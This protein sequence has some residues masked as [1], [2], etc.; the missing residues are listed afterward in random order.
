MNP[1]TMSMIMSSIAA[2]TVL[3]MSANHWLIAWVGLEIN[4]LAILPII[5]TEHHPRAMEATTKY[6]LIQA[7]AS[8]TIMFSSTINALETGQWDITQLTYPPATALLTIAL[9]MKLGLAPM[10]H[11][12]PEVMQGTKLKTALIIATWQKLAPMSL[13]YMTFNNLSTQILLPLALTSTLLAGWSALNQT[14]LRKIM[15]FS[16]IAHIGWMISILP[17]APT[18]SLIALAVY[19]IMTTTMFSSLLT[20][21]SKTIK[22]LGLMW[23]VS[24]LLCA[25][26]MLTLMSLAG[27]PPLSGFLPKWLILLELVS[28]NL[29]ATATLMAMTSLLSLA[30]YTRLAY[31]TT[32]TIPPNQTTTKH[33]WRFK[34]TQ[35]TI[36]PIILPMTALLL[37]L[38]P[39]ISA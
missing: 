35:T 5:A 24:P 37:P 15:A 6:F 22:D 20:C 23:T 26:S 29:T 2:G 1:L 16:S 19:I 8:S 10:H 32:L 12:L 11:W 18:T 38:T 14:Q 21:T 25:S 34:T 3:T 33:N 4:T 17:L 7:A 28:Q 27:L 36:M 31:T 13:L 30:F 9:A 39:M